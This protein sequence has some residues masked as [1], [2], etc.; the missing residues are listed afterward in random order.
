MASPQTT[1]TVSKEL[2]GSV[3][4]EVSELTPTSWQDAGAVNGVTWTE[5]LQ[6]S[7]LEN[8]NALDRQQVT[9]QSATVEFGMFEIINEAIDLITRSGIDVVTNIA[10]SPVVGASQVFSIG[11]WGYN[12]FVVIENQ[13]GDGTIIK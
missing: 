3:Q 1:E 7:T 2:F 6:V 4:I 13:N 12:D 5:N 11:E 10:A 8:N 9:D